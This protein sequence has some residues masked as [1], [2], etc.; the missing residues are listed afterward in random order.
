[1]KILRYIGVTIFLIIAALT[2]GV[3]ILDLGDLLVHMWKGY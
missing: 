2:I 3:M 1:M